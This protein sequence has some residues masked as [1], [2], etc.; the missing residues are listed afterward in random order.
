M[1]NLKLKIDN[2]L[3]ITDKYLESNQKTKE[4]SQLQFV[5]KYL[6]ESL[7]NSKEVD[8]KSFKKTINTGL[9][10]I[11][12]NISNNKY[13]VLDT[14]LA[15]L[16]KYIS[17]FN[18]FKTRKAFSGYREVVAESL[19][20]LEQ[21][22]I[23]LKKEIDGSLTQSKLNYGEIENKTKEIND[24]ISKIKED[25]S[26]VK[27]EF[28]KEKVDIISEFKNQK[29]SEF[30]SLRG[31]ILEL[32]SESKEKLKKIREDAERQVGEISSAT[33]SKFY[34]KY[35]NQAKNSAKFWYVLTI[36]SLLM[37][38]GA[39]TYWFVLEGVDFTNYY[40]FIGK[41]LTALSATI[42]ARYSSIQAS[43]NKVIET[44]LR[45]TQL[46]MKTFNSFVED[47]PKEQKDNLKQ[48]LTNKMIDQDEWINH[49]KEEVSSIEQ[50]KKALNKLGFTINI[51]PKNKQ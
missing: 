9:D 48:K 26:T 14:Q 11:I 40:N 15:D 7:K 22:V 18:N 20:L 33:Y 45:K 31:E 43:K 24:N 47:L 10:Y 32:K 3:E 49:D 50:L 2:I 17:Y 23:K 5:L 25:L 6:K 44:K 16:V 37:A 13:D 29:K 38:V 30:D 51:L 42:L 4:I 1:E 36:T 27:L 28:Q 41:A 46:E 39:S 8:F 34:E 19:N 21:D 12:S 35:A